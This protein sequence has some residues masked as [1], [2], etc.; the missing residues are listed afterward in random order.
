MHSRRWCE[1]V[2]DLC[3]ARFPYV[4]HIALFSSLGPER[5]GEL[6]HLVLLTKSST[7]TS[8]ACQIADQDNVAIG[9]LKPLTSCWCCS[10]AWVRL[11]V[12]NCYMAKARG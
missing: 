8:H 6:A 2:A 1:T 10:F 7:C 5:H 3:P 9:S 4:E 11:R 12:G